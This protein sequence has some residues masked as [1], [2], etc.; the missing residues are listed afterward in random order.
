MGDE[1]GLSSN[2]SFNS[3]A[4]T[5]IACDLGDTYPKINW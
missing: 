4:H 1:F 5:Q 2:L 3:K